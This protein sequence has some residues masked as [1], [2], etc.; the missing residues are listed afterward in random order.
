MRK[1]YMN[2]RTFVQSAIALALALWSW[3]LRRQVAARTVELTATLQMLD[4]NRK[5][6]EAL[7]STT[8]VGVFETDVNGLCV[9]VNDR[10][11]EIAGMNREEALGEGWNKALHPEYRQR[12]MTEWGAAVR[13]Q[14]DFH[15]EHCLRRPDGKDTWVIAQATPLRTAASIVAG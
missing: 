1:S 15:T 7:V 2:K 5:H 13:E 3:T 6:F 11:L 12:V 10:W 8:P 14:R 9:Y 4:S